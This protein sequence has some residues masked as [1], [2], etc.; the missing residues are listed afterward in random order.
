MR[1]RTAIG[2][3][4]PGLCAGLLALPAVASAGNDGGTAAPAGPTTATPSP[5]AVGGA[6]TVTPSTLLQRQVAVIRGSV[7]AVDGGHAVSLQVRAGA[8]AWVSVA[9]ATAAADGSFAISWRASR[10]GELTLRV[11]GSDIAS[12][13]SVTATPEVTLAVYARVIATWYGPGL[14]GNHTACGELLTK[15]IVGLADRTLPCGTPVSVSYNGEM[16]TMPVIDRGPYASN[17]ATIDLTHAAAL[18]LGMTQTS[19]VGM[20]AL[21]GPPI[22]PTNWFAPTAPLPAA[23]SPAATTGASGSAGAS[24]AGGATAPS[25]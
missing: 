20:L 9:S 24:I 7:P 18:E 8:N 3:A 17:G 13:S 11:L 1:A 2:L 25:A 16:L 15:Q 14:Y 5:T 23:G 10:T 12:A 21:P 22:A 4:I 6:L 19:T